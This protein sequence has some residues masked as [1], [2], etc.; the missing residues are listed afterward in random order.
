MKKTYEIP[1]MEIMLF[2]CVTDIVTT[3]LNDGGENGVENG[4]NF[5]D[6]LGL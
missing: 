3:S 2:G 1:E 4:V 5:G 6:L